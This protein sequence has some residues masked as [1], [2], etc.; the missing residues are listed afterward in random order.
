MNKDD[1]FICFRSMKVLFSIGILVYVAG[2]SYSSQ[3][4]LLHCRDVPNMLDVHYGVVYCKH[5]YANRGFT[6]WAINTCNVYRRLM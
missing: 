1:M 5:D 6:F 3:Y 4:N 2:N